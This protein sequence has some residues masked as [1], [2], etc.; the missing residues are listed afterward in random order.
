VLESLYRLESSYRELLDSFG[1]LLD[2]VVVLSHSD[3]F[4]PL[5]LESLRFELVL[6]HRGVF[7]RASSVLFLGGVETTFAIVGR[8]R[9]SRSRS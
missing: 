7:V 2:T 3:S 1:S 9:V 6:P 5:S 8:D 4:S